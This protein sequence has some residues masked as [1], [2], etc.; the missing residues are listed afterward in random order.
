MGEGAAASLREGEVQDILKARRLADN[1][2][3][4]KDEEQLDD[5]G[6]FCDDDDF[7]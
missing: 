6:Q 4:D 7:E 1:E 2:V 3:S 5:D